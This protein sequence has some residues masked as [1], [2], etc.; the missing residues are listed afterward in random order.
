LIYKKNIPQKGGFV[1]ILF[2]AVVVQFQIDP[3]PLTLL[4][5][6]PFYGNFN[7]FFANSCLDRGSTDRIRSGKWRKILTIHQ[8]KYKTTGSAGTME[9]GRKEMVAG[10]LS[11]IPLI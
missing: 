8:F 3:L 7:C 5:N 6:Y 9:A 2:R 10:Q 1:N 11:G 4:R